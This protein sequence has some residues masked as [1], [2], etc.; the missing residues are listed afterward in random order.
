MVTGVGIIG[1]GP[2]VAALH[3]PTVARLGRRFDVVHVSDAGSG[4]ARALAQRAGAAW[5]HGVDD[6]LADPGVEVVVV[7]SPPHRHA[8]QVLSAIAA[9]KRAILCEKPLA[10]TH[11]ETDAVVDAAQ[12][13][14]V[15]LVVGTNHLFDPAWG[16]ARHHVAAGGRIRTVSVTAALPPNIRYHELVTEPAPIAASRPAR[17]LT[18]RH[19]RA[20]IMRQ[21]VLGLLIHDLPLVRD[22]APHEPEVVF[23][24]LVPAPIGCAIGLRAGEVLVQL[25]AALLPAGAEAQ[26]RMTVGTTTD[27][28]EIDFPPSFVHG[29]SARVRAYGDGTR[30]TV[31]AAHPE[32]GYLAEWRALASAID[33]QAPVDH[34]DLR[35]DAHFAI[36]IADDAAAAILAG[37]S[38]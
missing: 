27:Q 28:F 22:L 37:A 2:G 4:R 30:E 1:A 35:A 3:M 14:G 31:Y 18:D 12:A 8:E 19:V 5:S 13:A 23:A 17:D 9:G 25:T 11:A 20:G 29:G 6:L 16:S 10:L 32:D 36:D 33:G 34:E 7:A 15:A 24:R 38:A 21:L 26:W